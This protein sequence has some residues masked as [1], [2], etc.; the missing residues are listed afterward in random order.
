MKAA[1]G[2]LT[3][4]GFGILFAGTGYAQ[5]DEICGESGATPW[6]NTAFVYGR[7]DLKGYEG[8][9]LPKITVV[10]LDRQNNEKRITVDRS[11]NYCF[12]ET[13]GSGGIIVIEVEGV[14]ATRRSLPSGGAPAP[15]RQDFELLATGNEKL[16]PPK[17]ISAKYNYPR[18]AKNSELFANAAVAENGKDHKK[19]IALLQELVA[20]DPMDYS[21]WAKLGAL[22]FDQNKMGDAETAFQSALKAK[23][24]FGPG[25]VNLGRIFLAQKQ[26]DKAIDV[27]FKAT[28]IEPN[29]ARGFQLLGEAYILNKK[30]SLGVE[31]LNEAIRLDP[32]GMAESHLLMAMLYDR[33]GYKPMAS[34]EY[35]IFLEK[36]PNHPD[37]KKFE[38]YI[39][40]NPEEKVSN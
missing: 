9:K 32:I 26:L 34:R 28:E 3:L 19:A 6:I 10:L 15:I 8:K 29:N 14:E 16:G 33:A 27:L 1:F 31:A 12:R 20:A 22:Y 30:G 40:D 17:T 7:L 13:N 24:D 2:I 36:V 35:R 4:I 5:T 23:P 25:M 38:K 11:G 18:N 37:K 21:A 39:K